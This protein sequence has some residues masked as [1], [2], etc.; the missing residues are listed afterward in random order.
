MTDGAG[1]AL[2]FDAKFA[3]GPPTTG[4]GVAKAGFE[5]TNRYCARDLGPKAVRCNLVSAG[6]DPHDRGE[7]HPRLRGV[8]ELA[9]PAGAT[10]VG[11]HNLGARRAG[12]RRAAVGLVPG[13]H[14]RDRAR[15]WW[16]YAMGQ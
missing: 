10:G 7:V 1:R 15:R 5:A 8:R 13:D 9:E 3:S 12:L 2:T 11:R 4:M 16:L 14:R 6:P